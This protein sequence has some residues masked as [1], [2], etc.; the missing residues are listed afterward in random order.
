MF[1]KFR[2]SCFIV[3]ILI[4]V[5]AGAAQAQSRLADRDGD[6]LIEVDSLTKLHNMR[7]NLAGTSYKSSATSVGNTLGCPRRGC[8]GY[9]LT[10]DLD[11]DA[12]GDGSSWTANSDGS[13]LLG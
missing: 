4:W 12:D 7:H 13:Y 5:L 11:F 3:G 1:G 6:G 9:E 2:Y 10:R 8:N